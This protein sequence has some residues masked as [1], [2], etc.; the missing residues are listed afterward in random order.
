MTASKQPRDRRRGR[1]VH[2]TAVWPSIAIL[3]S[4]LLLALAPTASLASTTSTTVAAG[5]GTSFV[6][7][8]TPSHLRQDFS[9]WVGMTLNVGAADLSVSALGRWVVAGNSAAHTVKVV[10]AA[11]GADVAGATVSVPTA[12][13][14]AG[15]FAYARLAA[16]VTL[17]AG[18]SYYLVSQESAGG[19]TWYD[20]DNHVVTTAA[21]TDTG[22]VYATAASPTGWTAGGSTGMAYVPPSFLYG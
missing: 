2:R 11:T 10:D 20:Y 7:S 14:A 12:G 1:Y 17:R 15:S 5:T 21:G 4:A 19:D 9:G 8:F 22:A 13:A 16:P 6:T 3:A 18:G